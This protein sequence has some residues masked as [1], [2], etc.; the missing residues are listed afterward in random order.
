M[1][2]LSMLLASVVLSLLSGCSSTSSQDIVRQQMEVEQARAEINEQQEAAAHKQRQQEIKAIP[3]WVLTPLPSD[4]T[5]FYAVG[6]AESKS[7]YFVMKKAKMQAEFELAKQYHQLLSGAERSFEQESATGEL[8]TQ[9]TVLIDKLIDEVPI[10]GYDIIQQK[11]VALNGQHTAYILLKMPYEQ[12]NK[13]LQTQK[14]TQTQDKVA[15]AFEKLQERLRARRNE[16][17]TSN[18]PLPTQK[19]ETAQQIN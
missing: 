9:T 18:R 14:D 1:K 4:K 17:R 6:I 5:G 12:Y 11:V 8:V 7:L 10:V 16:M 19:Q 3:D 2:V 15:S 13:V